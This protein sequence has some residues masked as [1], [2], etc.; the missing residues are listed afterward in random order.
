MSKSEIDAILQYMK[1]L[2]TQI[3]SFRE[4]AHNLLYK[5]RDELKGEM[6]DLQES[7]DDIVNKINVHDDDIEELKKRVGCI[8]ANKINVS[9]TTK[10]ILYDILTKVGYPAL[11]ILIG[12][13]IGIY[14][15]G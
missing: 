13:A 15:G 2:E 12:I 11:V 7:I 8:E 4:D 6:K 14:F 9:K 5:I 10:Q 1:S 3:S